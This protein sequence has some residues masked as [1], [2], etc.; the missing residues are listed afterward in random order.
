MR[1]INHPERIASEGKFTYAL[2]VENDPGLIPLS[3]KLHVQ[4]EPLES[5]NLVRVVAE[6]FGTAELL[7]V[8][9]T[10]KS[11]PMMVGYTIFVLASCFHAFNGLW[12]FMI[13]WGVTLSVRSQGLMLK[14]STLLMVLIALLGLSTIYL[15][16][17][18][19]LR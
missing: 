8:R 5:K 6:D 14:I 15:T 3:K 2:V 11:F 18:V 12:S 10:F 13:T 9:E 4:L 1:F 16:Y 17:W 7:L 19:T